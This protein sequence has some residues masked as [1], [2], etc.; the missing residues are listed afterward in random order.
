MAVPRSTR[1]RPARGRQLPSGQISPS[2]GGQRHIGAAMTAGVLDGDVTVR[3][4]TARS[5]LPGL[6]SHGLAARAGTGIKLLAEL[7]REAM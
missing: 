5:P 4:E 7:T 6:R 2:D 1:M 3:R